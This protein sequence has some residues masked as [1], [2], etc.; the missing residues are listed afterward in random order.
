MIVITFGILLLFLVSW[1]HIKFGHRN[2]LLSKI[3]SPRKWP[4][5]HNIPEFMGKSPL[6]LFIWFE[7]TKERLG[8][9]YIVT[10]EPFDSG[11]II[12]A[13]PK[14]AEALLTSSKHLQKS[15]DYDMMRNWLGDGLL[16]S[17]GQ[18]WRQRRK[19]LTSAFHFQ[20][21]EKFMDVMNDHGNVLVEQLKKTNGRAID[22]HEKLNLYA[23]DVICGKFVD[24]LL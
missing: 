21:L 11:S 20:I 15:N 22:V 2:K 12:V 17:I 8:N 10:F 4:L 9:V 7:K 18:K 3:P 23:L 14:V 13:D 19:I 1:Y 6:E 16:V 24:L 5:I